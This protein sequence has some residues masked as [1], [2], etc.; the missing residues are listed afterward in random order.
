MRIDPVGRGPDEHVLGPTDLRG[1]GF[2]RDLVRFARGERQNLDLAAADIGEAIARRRKGRCGRPIRRD[3]RDGP[4]FRRHDGQR[5][6]PV[7][8]VEQG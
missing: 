5:S 8:E 6:L 2:G 7:D 4:A 1:R 3:H